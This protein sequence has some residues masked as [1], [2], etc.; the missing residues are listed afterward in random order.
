MKNSGFVLGLLVLSAGAVRGLT[1]DDYYSVQDGYWDHASTWTSQP[2]AFGYP[3]SGDRAFVFHAVMVTTEAACTEALVTGRV[4]I[5]STGQ[6]GVDKNAAF[7]GARIQGAGPM[8]TWDRTTFTGTPSLVSSPWLNAGQ[9]EFVDTPSLQ[10]E[11][12]LV[13]EAGA[14]VLVNVANFQISGT[15]GVGRVYNQGT[16]RLGAGATGV[17]ERLDN[18]GGT[19]ILGTG[20]LFRTTASGS[21]H[22]N[23]NWVLDAGSIY[24]PVPP[25]GTANYDGTIASTGPGEWRMDGGT[26]LVSHVT[27]TDTT[28]N[29]GGGG[30]HWGDGTLDV[31]DSAGMLNDGQMYIHGV[32]ADRCLRGTFFNQGLVCLSGSTDG[33]PSHLRLEGT[34]V[35]RT[36]ATTQAEGGWVELLGT[37]AV[38]NAGTFSLGPATGTT[39]NIR[40]QQ[41]GGTVQIAAGGEFYLRGNQQRH[42][43]GLFVL[44]TDSVCHVVCG[45]TD[46]WDGAYTSTG[47]GTLQLNGGTLMA[48]H[49]SGATTV[50]A[51]TGGG[52]RVQGGTL[53]V[54][55]GYVLENQG[56]MHFAS[57]TTPLVL[58]GELRN[59]G[60]FLF[61]GPTPCRLNGPGGKI[62]NAE[63]GIWNFVEAGGTIDVLSDHFYNFGTANY[64]AETTTIYAPVF[65]MPGGTTVLARG[66]A[67]FPAGIIVNGG[68]LRLDGGNIGGPSGGNVY[69]LG[70]GGALCGTGT[71][72]GYVTHNGGTLA[73]GHSPGGL[74]IG[75]NY[76]QGTNGIL[77]IELGG[78]I[79]GT[80][81]D[82]LMVASNSSVRGTLT[83]ELY[84]GYNPAA[85]R[86]FDVILSGS[87]TATNFFAATNLPALPPGVDWLL[88]YRTN[89]IQLRVTSVADADGD[90]LVDDWEITHFGDT[91]SHDGGDEDS[92]DDGYTDYVEQCLDTQP[93]NNADYFRVK[94][95]A[96]SG[97]NGVVALHA[98]S[99]VHYAIETLVD[100]ADPAGE[101][102]VV[103]E[104]AGTG[105]ETA[106]TNATSG[107]LRSYR[108]KATAP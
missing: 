10:L 81:Y 44:E 47:P 54:R 56:T 84:G 46:Y 31:Y 48:N 89:G 72:S 50:F 69:M 68:Q 9:V 86:R 30:F 4:E 3:R 20:S 28:F 45:G 32:P 57:T 62:T 26:L 65:N 14:T 21:Q 104:F 78:K 6:L 106:R 71:V 55:P 37:G 42:T 96:V 40:F 107:G 75:G 92:D 90:G 5:A 74:S 94:D 73:P 49:Y 101:W 98:G 79:P 15:T 64:Q 83:V 77:Q 61:G 60:R 88:L 85:G 76:T 63:T 25:G 97:S 17:V 93:T 18:Q 51:I 70:G 8:K 12:T 2:A 103:D 29:V 87:L 66:T 11:N 33:P 95:I 59:S 35:N 38:Q 91:T 22:A 19:M 41:Q 7:N 23:G 100:L 1:T 53:N 27:T 58:Q 43:G 108:L 13:N 16:W 39:A 102:A 34:Y 80:E 99:N 36:G 67:S 24:Q 52:F 105:G 82:Q